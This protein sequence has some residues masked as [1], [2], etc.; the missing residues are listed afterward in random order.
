MSLIR[1]EF[2]QWQPL[3]HQHVFLSQLDQLVVAGTAK[4][5]FAFVPYMEHFV[6]SFKDMLVAMTDTVSDD[7]L[8][9]AINHQAEEKTKYWEWYIQDLHILEMEGEIKL[10]SRL[11]LWGEKSA[12][13]RRIA[14]EL[15]VI[16]KRLRNPYQK[17]LFIDCL[18]T[19]YQPFMR[20]FSQV[21]QH[22]GYQ[23]RLSYFGSQH[24]TNIFANTRIPWH[25]LPISKYEELEMNFAK[26]YN[27][28]PTETLRLIRRSFQLID[29]LWDFWLSK[30]E[31]KLGIEKSSDTVKQYA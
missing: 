27:L 10:L 9:T 2:L 13:S 28:L 24:L 19:A 15:A 21:V 17:M 3:L 11:D 7:A 5:A 4:Q 6:Y 30:I 8:Q 12:T 31:E 16:C 26:K 18:T 25:H 23:E 20:H 14:T 22:F 1:H 29:E